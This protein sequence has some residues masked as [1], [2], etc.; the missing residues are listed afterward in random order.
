M[1]RLLNQRAIL[2]VFALTVV[3]FVASGFIERGLLSAASV[4][5]IVLLTSFVIIVSFGQGLVILSGGLD[6]SVGA[7]ITLGG[8]LLGAWVPQSNEGLW[9]AIP[10]ILAIGFIFGAFNGFGVTVLRIPAFVMTLAT[11]IIVQSAVLEFTQGAPPA[12]PAPEVIS[13]LTNVSWYGVPLIIYVVAVLIVVGAVVQDMSTFGRKVHAIGGN[14]NAA[15]IAGLQS[16]W[17]TVA[18]YA[19]SGSC[20]AF[21]GVVL[22][23][24]V[25]APILS[26][27]DPYT[28]DSVAAVV[29]GGSSILGGL[30]AFLGTV[31]G[32]LFLGVL[33]ND[34]TALGMSAAWQTLIKGAV[35]VIALIIFRALQGGREMTRA[36]SV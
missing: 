27:G 18:C 11:G 26:M 4:R 14:P 33:S 36:E 5:T 8:V 34:M 30:G 20:A 1:T 29:V 31:G 3:L 35:I 24:F 22:L 2:S 6:L 19:I 21:C 25:G 7:I 13:D 9:W 16:K 32:A 10:T 12:T 28:L 15:V 23:G 17:I